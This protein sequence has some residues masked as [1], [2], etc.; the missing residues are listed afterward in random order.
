MRSR[1]LTSLAL[2]AIITGLALWIVFNPSQTFLGRDTS[3]R[4]GLD[5]QGGIQV[6]LRRHRR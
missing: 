3:L 5:L 1:E 2:I 4:L 6:L